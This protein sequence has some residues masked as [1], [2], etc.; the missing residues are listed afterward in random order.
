MQT[1]LLN[2]PIAQLRVSSTPCQAERR[3]HLDKASISELAKSIAGVGVLQPLVVRRVN[4][5]FEIVAGERRFL[6]AKEA[7]LETVPVTVRDL[8]D[9]QL[10]EVQ[11]VENLQRADV[12]PM[13]EAEGYEALHKL[14]RSVEEIAEKTGKSRAY[15]YGRMKLLDLGQAG[16]K[17]FYEGKLNASTALYVA[18]VPVAG[19]LQEDAVKEITRPDWQGQ[20]MS[21]RRALEH[22]QANYML[23]LADAPFKSGDAELVPAAGACGPCPKRTGNQKELFAD[24]K[25]ADVCTDPTCY[26]AKVAAYTE[27]AIAKASATGQR[28]I[29]GKEAKKVAPHG[30]RSLQGH[31]RLDD[32]DWNDPKNR[33]YRQILGKGYVPTLIVDQEKGELHEIAP[34]ADL[35]KEAKKDAGRD[36]YQEQAKAD[37]RKR[38]LEI[39]YRATVLRRLHEHATAN[40]GEG[41]QRVG[42][43]IVAQRL[44]QSLSHDAKAK[45]FKAL[46]WPVEKGRVGAD[47]KL[48]TP[49]ESQT[50]NQLLW[51]IQLL[52]VAAELEVWMHSAKKPEGL[53]DL[54]AD[55]GVDTAAIRKE[56]QAEAKAKSAKKAAAARDK[57]RGER[58]ATKMAE[59]QK[60]AKAAKVKA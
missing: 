13:A 39:K 12:H 35:P 1:E 59:N 20:S 38:D 8:T 49:F 51:T 48:P 33:T 24:V 58:R 34:V 42:M 28:V 50:E 43:D 19:G 23:R 46:D 18:R 6:A 17:A 57:A 44:W 27:Q 16:R 15:V 56:L 7:K 47:Y 29:Q 9:E 31:V 2:L 37:Q 55:R 22:L 10:L 26:R 60:A 4:G 54:A 5:H 53:E 40:L 45:L 41:L 11:L 25:G 14:G 3:K 36:R 30:F 21:A 32:R 52:A